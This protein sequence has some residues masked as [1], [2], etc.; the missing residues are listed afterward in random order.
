MKY[1]CGYCRRH[2]ARSRGWCDLCRF[3][4]EH[5]TGMRVS[6]IPAVRWHPA[7]P[8]HEVNARLAAWIAQQERRQ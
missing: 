4:V 3:S 8:A 7:P 6:K 1:L 2:P 5:V